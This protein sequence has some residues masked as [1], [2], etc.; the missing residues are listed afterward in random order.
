MDI[1]FL[2]NN[3]ERT[4]FL[5]NHWNQKHLHIKNAIKNIFALDQETIHELLMHD[6]IESRVVIEREFREMQHGPFESEEINQLEKEKYTYIIHNLNLLFEPLN[7]LAQHFS[8]IP[9][10]LF[11]DLMCTYSAKETSIGAHFDPYNVVI[12][13]AHGKRK[14]E[15]QYNFNEELDFD[16]DVKVLKDFQPD[17]EIILEPGDVLFIPRGCAHRGSSLEASLSYSVGFKA[18]QIDKIVKNYLAEYLSADDEKY[19]D[20]NKTG[21]DIDKSIIKSVKK[22]ILSLVEDDEALTSFILSQLSEPKN[23]YEF[24]NEEASDIDFNLSYEK[25]PDCKWTWLD[26][27][28]SIQLAINGHTYQIDSNTFNYISPYLEMNGFESFEFKAT[29]EKLIKEF[30]KILIHQE[31]FVISES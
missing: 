11:D 18:I 31:I 1:N 9:N 16:H 28:K 10:W 3:T 24:D 23:Y 19:L 20:I 22:E 13:Q 30:I 14:W 6:D 15:L 4:E 7:K 26:S 12:I 29:E 25:N 5:S 27:N 2:N 8:F 21:N 17:I